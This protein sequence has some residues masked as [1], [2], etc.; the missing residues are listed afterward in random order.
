MLRHRE[1]SSLN[2]VPRSIRS[3]V[4]DVRYRLGGSSGWGSV[5]A[6]KYWKWSV[7]DRYINPIDD[8]VDV[9]CGDL[10]FWD[11]R[12]CQR[13]V[14]IDP[15][16]Y[17]IKKNRMKGLAGRSSCLRANASSRCQARW[18]YVS[19]F[20]STFWIKMPTR[21]Q[22]RTSAPILKNGS[23]SILGTRIR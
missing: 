19:T 4:W 12:D 22:S 17:V 10:T 13:Y 2:Y 5:G 14:G 21:K 20:S 8:V 23:L 18:C 9:G 16:S 7:I 11:G 1:K 6:S 3:R 15:S